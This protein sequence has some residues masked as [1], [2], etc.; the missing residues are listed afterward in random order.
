MTVTD[1]TGCLEPVDAN[2]E[3]NIQTPPNPN[4][5]PIEPL[6]AGET[7]E[8]IANGSPDL[9][10]TANAYMQDVTQ[11]VQVF[12]PPLGTSIYSVTD[13]N[14]CGEGSAS[15]EVNVQQVVADVIP[16]NAEICLG[17]EVTLIADGAANAQWFPVAGLD[18]PNAISVQAAPTQSVT[19]NVVLTDDLGCSDE[20]SVSITVVPEPPGGQTY[21]TE[22]ICEGFGLQLPGAEGDQW[23]WSPAEFVN[24][25]SLQFPYASP[26]ETTTF[27]VAI[28]NVCGIGTDEM[29]VEVRVPEAYASEDGGMC[30][31]QSFE[32][33]AAG[34]DPNSTFQWQPAELVVSAG[35]GT[36]AGVP[37]L[38]P[39]LHGLCHRQRR[40]HGQR[41]GDGVR[42]PA[43]VHR[44]RAGPGGVVAGRGASPGQHRRH[45]RVLDPRRERR[46]RHLPDAGPDRA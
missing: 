1:P 9:E 24:D 6:C 26:E 41:R 7:V 23:L 27:S 14:E 25:A 42:D 16:G 31:G 20:A 28:A 35:S 11:A 4:I 12:E 40:V 15:I 17:D 13:V 37:Q 22:S 33:S 29:T 34:N 3:V 18:N 38:H 46:L 5:M 30:R 43:P 44:S 36:T 32:V 2:L 39:N 45:G 10:W 21:P 19:Y 8:L